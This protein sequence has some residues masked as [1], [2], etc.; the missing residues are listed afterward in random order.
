[1]EGIVE[2]V[3]RIAEAI[4]EI[5]GNEAIG[6]IGGVE[7]GLTVLDLRDPPKSNSISSSP[8]ASTSTT[9]PTES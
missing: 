3:G 2:I 9:R 4:V 8:T 1:V 5:A 7:N 6:A